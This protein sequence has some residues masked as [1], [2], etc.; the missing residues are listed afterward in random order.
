MLMSHKNILPASIAI[1]GGMIFA[2]GQPEPIMANDR[3]GYT[4]T[5]RPQPKRTQGGGS[6]LNEE[7]KIVS[8]QLLVPNTSKLAPEN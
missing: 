3:V 8:L 2:L 5:E 7:A 4:P 1:I 6:R